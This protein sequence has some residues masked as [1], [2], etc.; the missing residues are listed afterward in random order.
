MCVGENCTT[1]N[2]AYIMNGY[3]Q[4]DTHANVT[5]ETKLN[6]KIRC[7]QCSVL[8]AQCAVHGHAGKPTFSRST[9][10]QSIKL[11]LIIICDCCRVPIAF[12][13]RQID[14]SSENSFFY[15]LMSFYEFYVNCRYVDDV[16]TMAATMKPF[17]QIA[18]KAI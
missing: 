13:R 12:W 10:K 15:L 8:T 3:D 5:H 11:Q 18:W 6:G 7:A 9:N 1:T 14:I 16:H 4:R 17:P 2:V